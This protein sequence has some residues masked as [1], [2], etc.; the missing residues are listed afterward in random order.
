MSLSV[1][2]SDRL[3]V[4]DTGWAMPITNMFDIDGDETES[5]E[6]VCSIVAGPTQDDQWMMIS[7]SGSEHDMKPKLAN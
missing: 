7:L 5:I 2:L 3:V 6:D 1:C 4:Q